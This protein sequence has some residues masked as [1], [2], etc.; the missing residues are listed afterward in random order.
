MRFPLMGRKARRESR[1][2]YTQHPVTSFSSWAIRDTHRSYE[3]MV[4]EGYVNNPIAQ[5]AVRL[6]AEGAGSA[7]ITA[8]PADH[9]I[10]H[11]LNRPNPIQAGPDLIEVV[12]SHLSLHGNAYI[13]VVL[14]DDG[15]PV[16]VY[17]LRPDRV[18]IE[19]D[20][21]G[22]PTAYLY[23]AGEK[24]ERHYAEGTRDEPPLLHI[25]TFHPLDDHYGL[26]SL[27]AA[28]GAIETHNAAARWNKNLLD[29]AARPSGA[30]VFDPGEPG[31][32]LT[33]EQFARLK[34]EIEL[35]F[36]GAANAGRPML[37]EGGLKWQS[38]SLSPAEL[39]F[40]G[41]KASAAR[42][43]AL[44]F[45]VPPMLL[46]LPGDNTYANYQE[47]NRALWRLTLIPLLNKILSALSGFFAMWWPEL[48]IDIDRNAIPAL[49]ADR[50][51]LWRHVANATFLTDEEK[52]S[53]LGLQS[54]GAS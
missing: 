52:R 49:S 38:L 36:A 46:G 50:E 2:A 17:A 37:L 12:A 5:R 8:R 32:T 44:A 35:S 23:R 39:D 4:R 40:V 10:L 24:V 22:W 45:G 13:E 27:G 41:A 16:E 25:K 51:R 20:A 43:I 42:E 14:G 11:L 18:S 9:P 47:A 1:P 3:A 33:A 29:N 53:M 7:P 26:G 28:A 54:D 21:N 34:A 31:A 19:A 30:L 48:R 6:I 15:L